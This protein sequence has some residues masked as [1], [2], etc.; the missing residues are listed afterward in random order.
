MAKQ[1]EIEAL[2]SLRDIVPVERL[3]Y[4]QELV[5]DTYPYM[6]GQPLPLLHQVLHDAKP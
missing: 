4:L 2:R 3:R 1:S 6:L 5:R